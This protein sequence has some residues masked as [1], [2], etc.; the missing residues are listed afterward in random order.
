MHKDFLKLLEKATGRDE[1]VIAVNLDIRG[2]TQFSQSVE[3]LPVATYIKKVYLKIMKG[4]F[5]NAS[6]YKPTGDGLIVIIP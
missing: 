2:F 1:Y 3:S 5:K 4:Y 6:Y